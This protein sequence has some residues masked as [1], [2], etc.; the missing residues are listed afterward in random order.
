VDF[1]IE[2]VTENEEVKRS[3][4]QQLDKV[5]KPPPIYVLNVF[6]VL[7]HASGW[8]L[9]LFLHHLLQLVGNHHLAKG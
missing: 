6:P 7:A 9:C 2:A 4:F 8:V 5:S 3:I 1:V